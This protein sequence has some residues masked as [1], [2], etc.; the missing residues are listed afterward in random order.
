VSSLIRVVFTNEIKVIGLD[1]EP[2]GC[3]DSA[4]AGA[5]RMRRRKSVWLSKMEPSPE[6]DSWAEPRAVLRVVGRGTRVQEIMTHRPGRSK[7][8]LVQERAT[9]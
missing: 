8:I 3:T 1:V 2:G 9:S 4:T 5:P 7:C 6:I